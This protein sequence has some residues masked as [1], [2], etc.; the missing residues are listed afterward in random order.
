[1]QYTLHDIAK[2]IDHSLLRPTM[3]V[4]ELK[5]GIGWRG[6]IDVASVC[7]MPYYLRRCASAPGVRRAAEHDDRLSARRP[8]DRRQAGRGPAGA[9]RRRRRARH[10][11]EHQQGA[12]RRLGL[13][14]DE[15][16][17]VVELTHRRGGKVKVIFENCY[18][19]G[20]AQ[21]P[22]VR[23]LRRSAGRL[24]Q[25]LDRLRHGRRHVED[26]RLMRNTRPRRC[27]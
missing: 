13:R 1:M 14:G 23:D 18:P 19:A 4:E 5:Q 17:A 27:R 2:M 24:G 3:T 11:G 16:R 6:S 7:I 22:A 8:H 21:D 12:Q 26:L 15:I 20:R 9:G 25:D 10:G